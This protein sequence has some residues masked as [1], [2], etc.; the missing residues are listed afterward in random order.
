MRL[1][2]MHIAVARLAEAP[3]VAKGAGCAETKHWHH[4]LL[5]ELVEQLGQVQVEQQ[6]EHQVRHCVAWANAGER[7]KKDGVVAGAH[8]KVRAPVPVGSEVTPY[9]GDA[10]PHQSGV[11]GVD[12]SMYLG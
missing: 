1:R 12:A 7:L 11:P 6:D 9:R 10:A 2:Q 8:G 3:P 4:T 5:A